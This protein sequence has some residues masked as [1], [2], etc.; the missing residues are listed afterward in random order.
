MS[1]D[2][3]FSLCN[4]SLLIRSPQY[5]WK[6]TDLYTIA[7]RD[8]IFHLMMTALYHL[9]DRITPPG[10]RANSATDTTTAKD[11][12]REPATPKK[13]KPYNKEKAGLGLSEMNLTTSLFL[14][15]V[16]AGMRCAGFTLRQKYAI[17]VAAGPYAAGYDTPPSYHRIWPFIALGPP[18]GNTIS[19]NLLFPR[20]VSPLVVSMTDIGRDIDFHLRLLD[21]GIAHAQ[22]LGFTPAAVALIESPFI[23]AQRDWEGYPIFVINETHRNNITVANLLKE[24]RAMVKNLLNA[25]WKR[26]CTNMSIRGLVTDLPNLSLPGTGWTDEEIG[27]RPGVFGDVGIKPFKVFQE[28]AATA[29]ENK[30]G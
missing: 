28:G 1:L 7:N 30:Q 3:P 26:Y 2:L 22:S 20:P 24:E 29:P 21:M 18:S 13:T 8:D 25:G 12:A 5:P 9:R 14:A 4:V 17:L 19:G 16:S 6:A 10:D 11:P 15:L 23:S 27:E